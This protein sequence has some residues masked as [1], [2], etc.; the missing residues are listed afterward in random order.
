MA[1]DLLA[2]YL[3]YS[4]MQ[5]DQ[6]NNKKGA[7]F[8]KSDDNGVPLFRLGLSNGATAGT[9]KGYFITLPGDDGYKYYRRIN[10]IKQFGATYKL[11]GSM[12]FKAINPGDYK[13]IDPST[14]ELLRKYNDLWE[15]LSTYSEGLDKLI[16]DD[17]A[18]AA[19]YPQID[20]MYMYLTEGVDQPGIYLVTC[21]SKNFTQSQNEWIRATIDSLQSVGANPKQFV[22]NIFDNDV[23]KTSQV[24]INYT[25][26]QGYKFS[27]RVESLTLQKQITLDKDAIADLKPLSQCYVDETSVD[28]EAL[29]A[30]IGAMTNMIE[31]CKV[32]SVK[33]TVNGGNGDV[34][35]D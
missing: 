34:F 12:G 29:Q 5:E 11:W 35:N 13:N 21:K 26:N 17:R 28:V 16:N 8:K 19:R 20:I 22:D 10:N 25:L 24:V 9:I 3:A 2:D 31:A 23:T 27:F 1:N 32:G 18:Y 33:A 14:R 4:Q 7:G 6:Q 15:E 30:A